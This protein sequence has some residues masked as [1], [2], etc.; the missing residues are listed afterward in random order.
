M[1][2]LLY[3]AGELR[4]TVRGGYKDL[5]KYLKLFKLIPNAI[6]PS[7]VIQRERCVKY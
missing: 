3:W 5:F 4:V 1:R 6:L 2:G 7:I